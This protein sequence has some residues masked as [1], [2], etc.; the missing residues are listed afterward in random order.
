MK[1][2][3]TY[4]LVALVLAL[5]VVPAWATSYTWTATGGTGY[6]DVSGNWSP[7]GI[8]SGADTA[9]VSTLG[10]VVTLRAPGSGNSINKLNIAAGAEVQTAGSI[11]APIDLTFE[12][13]GETLTN[14]G[15][16]DL[17]YNT[18]HNSASITASSTLTF[19]GSGTI[20]MEA[21]F[22]YINGSGYS[23][24][25]GLD[26][27]NHKIYGIGSICYNP[28]GSGG[29]MNNYGTIQAQA[30]YSGSTLRGNTL[31]MLGTCNN[32]NNLSA[33][34][35][36]TLQFGTS[37]LWFDYEGKTGGYIDLN[38]GNVSLVGLQNVRNADIR[39]S[40]S[41]SG[42]IYIPAGANTTIQLYRNT[43]IESG[44]VCNINASNTLYLSYDPTNG[45][46]P[47]MTNNGVINVLG[48][49]TNSSSFSAD[50]GALLTGSG[51]LVLN[52]N[53]F[54]AGYTPLGLTQDVNHTIEG[55]GTLSGKIIN[56]GTILANNGNLIVTGN[57]SG[58]GQ[59]MVDG[60]RLVVGQV[61]YLSSTLQNKD[62]IMSSTGAITVISG[63]GVNLSG[64]FSYAMT[65]PSKWSWD[66]SSTLTMS[67]AGPAWHFLEAGGSKF[68]IPNLVISG[69]IALE[70]LYNN[71][72]D[73]SPE[74]L[75]VNHLSF[76][77]STLDLNGI[78]LYVNGTQV[79]PTDPL[80]L[81]HIIDTPVPPAVPLPPSA[82]LLG[83]GL[84]GL[85][86][87]RRFRKS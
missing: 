12:G 28:Y 30:I 64:N 75:Y 18:T 22:N 7:S 76:S 43:T 67:G 9:N 49:P 19:N 87:W 50:S 3:A 35:G 10:S 1:R 38:G 36:A 14:N 29:T 25:N 53:S 32:Y 62:L 85:V 60:G 42:N 45:Q 70:D 71:S 54:L 84:A 79:L 21:P 8:P 83:T 15:L 51:S 73:G 47:V 52:G 34:P 41:S 82:L 68:V 46:A 72:G 13:S 27:N 37:S 24:N 66:S 86:G 56:N 2:K 74:A 39:N 81:G 5:Y 78:Q 31:T 4:A 57:I 11:A 59:V 63:W 48:S 33:S 17:S 16:F 20:L 65:D 61:G 26:G 40:Q 77:G 6:W 55:G 69:N 58:T 44:V 80:Y 23:I